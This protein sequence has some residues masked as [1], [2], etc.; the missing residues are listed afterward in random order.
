MMK[1]EMMNEV[2][3]TGTKRVREKRDSTTG[4][5]VLLETFE[6]LVDMLLVLGFV[7]IEIA[8]LTKTKASQPRQVPTIS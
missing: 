1:S 6:A 8:R 7:D 2:K 3:S 4:C 5:S